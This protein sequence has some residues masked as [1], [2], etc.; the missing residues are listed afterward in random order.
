MQIFGRNF[1][2][3]DIGFL[4][5]P[6]MA[7]SNTTTTLHHQLVT[8]HD[9]ERRSLTTQTLGDE[10]HAIVG[11]VANDLIGVKE[12]R[13]NLIGGV[14]QSTQQDG[15]RQLATTVNPNE[16]LI[17]RIEFEVQPGTTIRNDSCGVQQLAGAVGLATVVVEEHTRRAV[18]L[19]NDN[20]LG[21]IDDEGTILGHQGNLTHVDLLL[22]NILDRAGG[23]TV[24]DHQTNANSQRGRVCGAAQNTFLD[25]KHRLAKLI[26]G[27]LQCSVAR[28]AGNREHRTESSFQAFLEALVSRSAL[29]Q[30]LTIGI[31]LDCE[32]VR[33]LHH[34]RE[35]AEIFADPLFLSE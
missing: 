6:D 8:G 34:S 35:L 13:Q 5:L 18:Q 27:I 9:I 7:G 22:A 11:T 3:L 2:V 33:H 20:A 30:E 24:V 32:K 16:Y 10:L 19:G 14:A 1:Q 25:V 17:L 28:I 23:L 12:H 31:K 15:G 4:E 29:L 26:A 21:T